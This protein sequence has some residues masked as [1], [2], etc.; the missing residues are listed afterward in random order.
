MLLNYHSPNS[1][2]EDNT[3]KKYWFGDDNSLLVLI[4]LNLHDATQTAGQE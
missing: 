2:S 4:Q 1:N 3:S